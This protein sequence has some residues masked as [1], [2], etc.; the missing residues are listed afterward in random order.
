MF[1]AED[2]LNC[3]VPREPK[4]SFRGRMCFVCSMT[5]QGVCR[6]RAGG[7]RWMLLLGAVM[8]LVGAVGGS[9]GTEGARVAVM[10]NIALRGGKPEAKKKLAP[11]SKFD[12][13]MRALDIVMRDRL[14]KKAAPTTEIEKTVANS[15]WRACKVCPLF[16]TGPAPLLEGWRHSPHD[17]APG[18]DLTG[19]GPCSRDRTLSNVA[20]HLQSLHACSIPLPLPPTWRTPAAPILPPP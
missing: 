4:D 12:E 3:S 11:V 6:G 13:N 1:G 9:S 14:S 8:A 20:V 7:W 15:M 18:R 16:A 19:G 2:R 10:R 17:S 5:Q